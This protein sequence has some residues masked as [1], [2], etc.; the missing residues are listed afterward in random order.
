M[1]KRSPGIPEGIRNLAMDHPSLID[2][3]KTPG[4]SLDAA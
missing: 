2:P 3:V 1:S 4:S